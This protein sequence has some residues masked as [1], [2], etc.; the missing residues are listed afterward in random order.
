M[1]RTYRSGSKLYNKFPGATNIR[2]NKAINTESGYYIG[3]NKPSHRIERAPGPPRRGG[4]E[5]LLA[6]QG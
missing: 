5:L 4:G 3:V 1:A 6:S 2:E